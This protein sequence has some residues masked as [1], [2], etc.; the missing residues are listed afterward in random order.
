MKIKIPFFLLIVM[1]TISCTQQT[2]NNF[3]GTNDEVKLITLDPGHFHA[4]LVQKVMH[5]QID[6]NVFVYAP[7]SEDVKI[8]LNLINS[9]NARN[10]NP[11][12]WNENVYTGDDFLKKMLDEKKGNVVVISGNNRKKTEYI[13]ESIKTGMNVLAD[14]PMVI[15]IEN[16]E[17]LK[18]AFKTAEENNVLLYDIMTER[19]EI[20]TIL[21]KEISLIPEIFGSLEYGSEKDPAVI[22]ESIHNFYKYV[23][24][25]VLKRPAWFFDVKQQGEGV[26]DITT[27]LVDLVQWQCFPEKILDYKNDIKI[28]SA[29]RWPTKITTEQFNTV[30]GIND[31]PE[32]LKKDLH[33][34]TLHVYCNGE[35]NYKI[36]GVHAKVY[37]VWNY[38]SP[39][40]AGDAVYAL[41]RGTK[42]N[43][44]ILQ[45]KEQN[46]KP[47]LYI[48]PVKGIDINLFEN[49]LAENFKI[50]SEKYKG[51]SLKKLDTKWEV[52]I[53]SIYDVGHEAH[54]ADVT[55]RYLQYLIDGKLPDW[56][57]PNMLAKYYTTTA[58]L[59]MAMQNKN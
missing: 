40:D 58:A 12:N 45:G 53:P 19:S 24:G 20:T 17:L 22:R 3:L 16:F 32:F 27:H 6:P 38:R 50:I 33:N 25:S 7:E 23:S 1:I 59:E 15:D 21:Q 35:I 37:I 30:T 49:V 57:I 18:N 4:A 10:E 14:K 34:D 41:M 11:T 8:H 43:L 31:F 54:F 51:V 56:E 2:K 28:L 9:Y 29:N 46:Y 5:D 48:Q 47:T 13:M 26:A 55:S 36:K 52:E 44:I 42:S 39:E